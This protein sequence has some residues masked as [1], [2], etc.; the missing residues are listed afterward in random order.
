MLFAAVAL[1]WVGFTVL[2]L[3]WWWASSLHLVRATMR[4][5]EA[6]LILIALFFAGLW[7]L[8]TALY[9][10]LL[11]LLGYGLVDEVLHIR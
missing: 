6:E 10:V 11:P 2:Q 9:L 1:V 8:H 7:A 3:I 4:C 5:N